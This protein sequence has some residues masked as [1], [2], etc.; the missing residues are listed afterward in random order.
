MSLS[1]VCNISTGKLNA[2][3]MV[4]DGKYPFFTC[5]ANPFRIDT[6]S[7]DTEAILV[8]GNGSQVGHINYY[9]GK[10]DAYQR[11]YVFDKFNPKVSV[12][13]LLFYLKS[14][15]KEHILKYCKKGSV[16]YITLPMLEMFKIPVPSL[17]EQERIVGILDKFDALVSNISQGLPAEID[18][19]R[20]QYEYYRNKLLTF[21]QVV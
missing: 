5:D 19:R 21:P 9:K 14:F 12:F 2:N 1:E 3:A 7:F 16:P 20:K 11:T 13:Y 8:S 17:A 6:Y 18:G 15:L 4:K 10:F